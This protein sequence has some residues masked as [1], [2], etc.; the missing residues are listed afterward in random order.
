MKS[1]AFMGRA[2]PGME[3][4]Q[5]EEL[6]ADVSASTAAIGSGFRWRVKSWASRP[7][8]QPSSRPAVQP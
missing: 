6:R 8:V 1:S 3:G 5:G 4:V 7:A 2:E